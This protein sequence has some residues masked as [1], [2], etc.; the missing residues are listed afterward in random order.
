MIKIIIGL[1]III[2]I[3]ICLLDYSENFEADFNT[4]TN[5]CVIRKKRLNSNFIYTFHQSKYCDYYHD[6]YLRV[7][8][9]GDIVSG[10]EFKMDDCKQPENKESSTFG[11]CRRLGGFECIDFVSEPDCK[12]YGASLI[13]E[14][15]SCNN[16]TSVERNHYKTA[17][18]KLFKYE[19]P[20]AFT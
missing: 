15:V 12:K 19:V 16:K 2:I 10:K 20:L 3:I 9:E 4:N 5:C 11:S 14:P 7:I 18:D 1:I 6:N 17:V 13:W 8:K